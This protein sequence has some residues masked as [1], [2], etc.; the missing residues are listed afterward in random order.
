MN[1]ELQRVNLN[2]FPNVLKK[3]K[4]IGAQL[5]ILATTKQPLDT[6]QNKTTTEATGIYISI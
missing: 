4:Q 3:K 6:K 5:L 2:S 1:K